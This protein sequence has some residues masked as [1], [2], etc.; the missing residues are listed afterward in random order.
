VHAIIIQGDIDSIIVLILAAV[1]AWLFAYI[2][3]NI[4]VI[5]LRRRR[6][7]LARPFRTP[8]F[9]VPQVLAC[10]GMLTTIWYIAPPGIE[11]SDVYIRF[12]AMLALVAVFA[13][14]QTIVKTKAKL[15]DPVD[16]EVLARE[17]AEPL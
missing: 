16:P 8:W 7:D 10:L 5:V 11:R 14:W 6:P 3:V 1:C 17:E 4:S 13:V 12:F 15:F 2:L 9:P